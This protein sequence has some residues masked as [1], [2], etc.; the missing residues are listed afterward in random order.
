MEKIIWQKIPFIFVIILFLASST[1]LV[2]AEIT[3]FPLNAIEIH[4]TSTSAAPQSP[5]N[6][7]LFTL[8]DVK[9]NTDIDKSVTIDSKNVDR[10]YYHNRYAVII[11]GVYQDPQH[12]K[13]FTNDAQRQYNVLTEKYGFSYDDVFVLITVKEGKEWDENLSCDPSI[14]DMA[15]TEANIKKVFTKFTSGGEHELDK[16]DLLVVE[17]ISH[18]LDLGTYYGGKWEID[19]W[20]NGH[21]T[22]FGLE[23][24]SK[25]IY[26]NIK[27]N[28]QE[29]TN[30]GFNYNGSL[31]TPDKVFDWELALYTNRIKAR[32]I[33]FILQP[34][35]SGGFIRELSGKNRVICS[36]SKE[37]EL[38]LAPFIGFFYQGLNGSAD[39]NNDG[40][41][42]LGEV[43][44][45]TADEIKDHL[46][47]HPDEKP[48]HPLIDDNGDKK[49]CRQSQTS[50]DPRTKGKDGYVA[51]RIF[52]LRY[53]VGLSTS[54][55]IP[56]DIPNNNF[57]QQ[58]AIETS[59]ST[60]SSQTNNI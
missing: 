45:Y 52:D 17:V 53:E 56:H 27:D 48:Q 47:N 44:E 11:V 20:P 49:G 7:E 9:L 39:I 29:A 19:L 4:N 21:D 37:N 58:S 57:Q 8:S 38:A 18:G 30:I 15:S 13:W 26:E 10:F 6:E 40:K 54:Q 55:N 35:F 23:E 34:C 32:R 14:I 42:S 46:D 60:A 36:A 1:T 43:Y 2:N 12:Y 59:S 22:Y 50:Y 33:V 5:Y 51:A 41:I 16:N 3:K 25:D 24:E 31:L 28:N